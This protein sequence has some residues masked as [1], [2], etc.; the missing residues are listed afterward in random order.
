MATKKERLQSDIE[1]EDV[2]L[3]KGTCQGCQKGGKCERETIRTPRP[4]ARIDN[5]EWVNLM[6]EW[7]QFVVWHLARSRIVTIRPS[8]AKQKFFAH[9]IRLTSLSSS[10]NLIDNAPFN[11]MHLEANEQWVVCNWEPSPWVNVQSDHFEGEGTTIQLNNV[12]LIMSITKRIVWNSLKVY[13]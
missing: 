2:P 3:R 1:S 7:L 9:Q 8:K 12:W 5:P 13:L 10:S 4:P 6:A 11:P